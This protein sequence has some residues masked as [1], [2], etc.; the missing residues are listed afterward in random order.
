VRKV[1]AA[2]CSF[3]DSGISSAT[4]A[5]AAASTIAD[6]VVF[7]D[8][9]IHITT[10]KSVW[11]FTRKFDLISCTLSRLGAGTIAQHERHLLRGLLRDNASSASP[12]NDPLVGQFRRTRGRRRHRNRRNAARSSAATLFPKSSDAG[13]P[14]REWLRREV[15]SIGRNC[16]DSQGRTNGAATNRSRLRCSDFLLDQTVKNLA[17]LL[18]SSSSRAPSPDSI[19]LSKYLG[20]SR[21][22]DNLRS[23]RAANLYEVSR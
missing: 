14:D 13:P 10:D 19:R 3:F 18:F 9:F 11:E 5:G 21:Y 2:C 6:L 1:T 15:K 20:E 23:V 7:F 12:R 22:R 17:A 8:F 4:E 16:Y